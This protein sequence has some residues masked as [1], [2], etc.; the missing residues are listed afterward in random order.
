L[1]LPMIA[2]GGDGV[3]SVIA[4]AYPKDFSEM[5]RS[6]LDGNLDKARKL[7]Y[8]LLDITHA[9]FVDGNPSGVKGLL[10][11]MNICPEHLRLPL[12]SVS[13]STLNKFET[14]LKS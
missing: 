9:I 1:A 6:A 13:K 11:V 12:V 4:N 5:I 3:I 8:K 14:M 7:H 10:S 2:C